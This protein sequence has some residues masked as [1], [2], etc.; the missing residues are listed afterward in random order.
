MNSQQ[1]ERLLTVDEIAERLRVKPSWVYSHQDE[2]GVRRLGKYLRFLWPDV[3]ER[4]KNIHQ[5]PN[6]QS[7][8]HIR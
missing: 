2:L 6:E 4:L 8:L 5:P 1:A 3:L 7:E